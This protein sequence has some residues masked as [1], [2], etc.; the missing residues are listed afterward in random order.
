VYPKAY[1]SAQATLRAQGSIVLAVAVIASLV[2][3][4]QAFT[5]HGQGGGAYGFTVAF[6][7]AT[8]TLP[9]SS[10]SAPLK[11]TTDV[12]I[13]I[14]AMNQ[15]MYLTNVTFTISWQDTTRSP[16]TNPTVSATVTGPN[17]TGSATNRVMTSGTDI[18]ITVPNEMPEN[19]TT[20]QAASG[21]EAVTTAAGT[22]NNATLG[23]GEW[24]VSLVVGSPLG[25]RLSGGISYSIDVKVEYFAGTATRV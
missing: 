23:V 24:T 19:Q 9:G 7:N 6:K 15:T 16:F 25:P 22:A 11:T 13:T 14:E 21:D 4:T 3:G 1:G 20:V 18:A 2:V 8:T 5:P 17:G 12:K 10:G